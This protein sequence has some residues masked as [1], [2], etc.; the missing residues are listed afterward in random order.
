MKDEKILDTEKDVKVQDTKKK[1]GEIPETSCRKS[2]VDTFEA[3][4]NDRSAAAP[5]C[6]CNGTTTQIYDVT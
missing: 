3:E 1:D 6:D 4:R 2:G 5:D